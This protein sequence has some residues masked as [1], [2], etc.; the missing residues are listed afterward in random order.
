M[1]SGISMITVG[2]ETYAESYFLQT[3]IVWNLTHAKTYVHKTPIGLRTEHAS[4]W[5]YSLG[6]TY[7]RHWATGLSDKYTSVLDRKKH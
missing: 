1:V 6:P 7:L 3:T 4:P 2:P 5:A